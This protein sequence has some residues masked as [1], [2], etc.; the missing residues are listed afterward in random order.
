[1]PLLDPLTVPEMDQLWWKLIQAI[2]LVGDEIDHL[3][4]CP[5]QVRDD[6]YGEGCLESYTGLRDDL[7]DIIDND[8]DQSSDLMADIIART[9][10]S[11]VPERNTAVAIWAAKVDA[12]HPWFRHG[13]RPP[14]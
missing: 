13:Q 1:M 12:F 5:P 8:V 2:G 3:A 7:A 9:I 11:A 10:L 14:A 6:L 4:G